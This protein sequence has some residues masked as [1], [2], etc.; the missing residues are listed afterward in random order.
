MQNIDTIEDLIV[1]QEDKPETHRS[2]RQIAGETGVSQSS[3]VRI[4][5]KD[6]SLKCCKL[7]TQSPE[8]E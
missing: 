3:A 6:L 4:V 2:T 7:R 5:N 1:S 8:T